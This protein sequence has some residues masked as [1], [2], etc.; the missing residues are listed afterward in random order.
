MANEGAIGLSHTIEAKLSAEQ[1][2][3][4]IFSSQCY[5]EHM[6]T[7]LETTFRCA[8]PFL[9]WRNQKP[10]RQA[11]ARADQFYEGSETIAT[12]PRQNSSPPDQR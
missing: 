12:P 8:V 6:D 5:V 1:T 9:Q 2:D 4:W 10:G 3:R 7:H 11:T